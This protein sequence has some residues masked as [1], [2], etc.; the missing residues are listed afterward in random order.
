MLTENIN[1]KNF[2]FKKSKTKISLLFNKLLKQD[3]EI[4]NSSKNTY[5]NSYNRNLINK[6]KNFS[7][8]VVIGMGGS[9]LGSK[10]IYSFLKDKIKKNFY[11]IDTFQFY[12]PRLKKKKIKFNYF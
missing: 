10:S 8:I 2:T 4:L 1:F 3:N 6:F 11:F 5:L 7:E 12:I 9:I